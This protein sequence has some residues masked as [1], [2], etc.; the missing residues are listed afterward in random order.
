MPGMTWIVQQGD[1]FTGMGGI[2]QQDYS[3]S[4]LATADELPGGV[5]K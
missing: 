1:F 3:I 2:Q 4:V 5:F